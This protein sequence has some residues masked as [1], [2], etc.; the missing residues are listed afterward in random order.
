[1]MWWLASACA[2]LQPEPLS[3]VELDRVDVVKLPAWDIDAGTVDNDCGGLFQYCVRT[4]CVVRSEDP[5]PTAGNIVFTF[6]QRQGHYKQ[7]KHVELGPNQ[8]AKVAAT[9]PEARLLGGEGKGGCE[10]ERTGTRVVCTATNRGQQSHDVEIVARLTDAEGVVSAEQRQLAT[11][12]PGRAESLRFTFDKVNT[13]GTCE[14]VDRS[15][16][17]LDR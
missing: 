2:L 11:I 14:I 13:A 4:L 5:E 10:V 8:E 1:M 15:R 7:H 6:D 12:A 17:Q 3:V 16:D 9:F